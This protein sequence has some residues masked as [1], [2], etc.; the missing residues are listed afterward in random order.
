MDNRKTN[1]LD[2]ESIPSGKKIRFVEFLIPR[3]DPQELE[4]L[5][6]SIFVKPRR[7]TQNYKKVTF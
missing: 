1:E 2:R 5:Y 4:K 3:R 6:F 7:D